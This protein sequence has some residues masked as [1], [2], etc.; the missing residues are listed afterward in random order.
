MIEFA[1]ASLVAELDLSR[2]LYVHAMT[3]VVRVV[4]C[5]LYVRIYLRVC[6]VTN[7]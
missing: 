2:V 5:Q 4:A 7:L 1:C 3:F 6:A